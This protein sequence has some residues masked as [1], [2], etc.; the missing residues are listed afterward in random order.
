ML[1]W[2]K[3]SVFVFCLSDKPSKPACNPPTGKESVC[4]HTYLCVRS[5]VRL[6][7]YFSQNWYDQMSDP[8]LLVSL[9]PLAFL[10]RGEKRSK[11]WLSATMPLIPYNH[12]DRDP[13]ETSC[14]KY[15]SWN[16]HSWYY[17]E[18]E[19]GMHLHKRRE[20]GQVD[21]NGVGLCKGTYEQRGWCCV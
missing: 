11:C 12:I 2:E 13:L 18:R 14:N 10:L 15:S 20:E 5:R 16:T 17:T 1:S 4:V 6:M 19:W 7:P 3:Q 9:W 21:F 8:E